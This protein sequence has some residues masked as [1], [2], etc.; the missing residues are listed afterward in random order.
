MT[1]QTETTTLHSF[2]ELLPEGLSEYESD[3]THHHGSIDEFIAYSQL[4]KLI[5][6][7]ASESLLR[8]KTRLRNKL[9]EKNIPL[10]YHTLKKYFS[11][12]LDDAGK[13]IGGAT[14]DDLVQ[15]GTLG[16]MSAVDGFDPSLGWKF[17]TYAAWWI[18][19]SIKNH[20]TES[21]SLIKT[22]THIRAS[23]NKLFGHM[24]NQI[25]SE[26]EGSAA[27]NYSPYASLSTREDFN[28]RMNASAKELGYTEK[29]KN[30]IKCSMVTA[31]MLYMKPDEEFDNTDC[32]VDGNEPNPSAGMFSSLFSRSSNDDDSM[33]SIDTLSGSLLTGTLVDSVAEA[34]RNMD[35][36]RRKVLLLRFSV[37]SEE[38][39][40]N[41]RNCCY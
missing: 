11:N 22:P 19:Q 33:S 21:N 15:E 40:D 9:V 38:D 30:N 32:S 28:E 14:R 13:G 18:R 24:S 5:E 7:D 17:S 23:A 27:K 12:Q 1:T 2:H 41:N 26:T 36:K 16:L 35:E 3:D 4:N 20:I 25:S 6:A 34:L 29:L 39:L 10:V 31:N 37:L 8:K